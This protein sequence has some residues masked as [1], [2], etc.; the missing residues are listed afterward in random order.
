MYN[1]IINNL[2][3]INYNRKKQILNIKFNSKNIKLEKLAKL[4]SII[5]QIIKNQRIVLIIDFNGNYSKKLKN[6]TINFLDNLNISH[7]ILINKNS[8]Q[9]T[10]N[11]FFGPFQ[12]LKKNIPIT[13]VRSIDEAVKISN[14]L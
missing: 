10:L 5:K 2:A 9:N 3:T 8:L 13:T 4:N 1:I 11:N 14:T 6:E 7:I 12:P